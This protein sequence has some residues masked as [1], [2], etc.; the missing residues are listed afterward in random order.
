MALLKRIIPCLDVRDGRVVK[1]EQFV[2]LKDMGDPVELAKRYENAGADEIV[3]LDISASVE[4]RDTARELVARVAAEL[5]IPFTVGG[6]IRSLD[7]IHRLLNAGADKVSLN[8]AALND[9]E[10]IDSAARHYGAQCI[11]VAIDFR[12]QAQDG[13]VY[14]HGGTR[15]SDRNISDWAHE[16]VQRGAGELLLTCIDRDGSGRGFEQTI[17]GQLGRELHVPVI[18]SGGAKSA[19][20]FVDVLNAG[21]DAA[22]AAGIFHRNEVSISTVKQALHQQGIPVRLTGI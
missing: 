15:A 16:A 5:S 17:T 22:L 9:P 7:D 11:V 3:L 4:S 1:G 10:L 2:Q 18:A 13:L 21:A 8:S 19:Q 12:D 6:G 14:S 20:D